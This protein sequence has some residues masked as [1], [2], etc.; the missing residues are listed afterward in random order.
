YCARQASGFRV[1]RIGGIE[2]EMELPFAAIHQLCTPML[3]GLDAL[4]VPQQ[5][6]LGVALG[7]SSGEVPNRFLVA[8][9]VLSLM[10]AVAEEQPLLCLVDDAHW[11]DGASGQ[12]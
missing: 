1:A 9:A 5:N 6:A 10:S 4:P 3:G 11:L 8:L 2:A 12:V 7:L